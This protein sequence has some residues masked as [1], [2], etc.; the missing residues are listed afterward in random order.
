MMGHREAA[1]QG[2]ENWLKPRPPNREKEVRSNWAVESYRASRTTPRRALR[3][4]KG[5]VGT[6]AVAHRGIA[7]T[8]EDPREE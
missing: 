6:R 1:L 3:R 5:L 2:E 4:G 7:R 8:C